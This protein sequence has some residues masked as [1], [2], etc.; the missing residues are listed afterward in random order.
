MQALERVRV[1][2]IDTSANES[3]PAL[4]EVKDEDASI[5]DAKMLIAT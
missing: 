1:E 3:Q 2:F 4:Q 5:D